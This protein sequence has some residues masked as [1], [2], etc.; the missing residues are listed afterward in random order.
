MLKMMLC[1]E[2]LHTRRCFPTVLMEDTAWAAVIT[3]RCSYNSNYYC[4]AQIEVTVAQTTKVLVHYEVYGD[5]SLGP[6][7]DPA[8]SSLYVDKAKKRPVKCTK[9]FH[10]D[11]NSKGLLEYEVIVRSG[12]RVEFEFE[13]G[14]K[15]NRNF[16]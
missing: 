11:N 13:F 3:G 9:T 2:A 16:H 5:G 8:N 4:D 14:W 10:S 15:Q 6:I 1:L 7:Q 12:A